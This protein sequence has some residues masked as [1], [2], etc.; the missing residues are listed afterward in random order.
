MARDYKDSGVNWID[1]IPADWEVIRLKN[2]FSFGKG[3][4]ITKE[5]L[6]ETGI[7]V[8]SYGQIHGKYNSGVRIH[9]ELIR[10]VP[11]F[12]LSSN[13]ESLVHE[14]DLILADTSEDLEGCGNCAYIDHD[15]EIFAG[16]HTIILKSASPK[17]NKYIA[18]L[19]QTDPWRS[20]IRSKV[21][22]V[23][24]LS[25]S[26]RIISDATLLLP[27]EDEQYRIADFLDKK[28][29]EIDSVI[30][31][32][33]RTIEEYKALR[34]ATITKAITKGVRNKR[35]MKD[36]G[37]VWFG[38]IPADWN[39]M[40]LKYMFHIKKDIAGQEGYTV[41]SITQKGIIPK[42][43]ANNEGQLAADYSKYQLVK[44]GDFAMNHMD[45]LTGWVDISK[46]DGVTSPDYR[47]F[48]LDDEANNKEYYL[49]MMQMCY[50]NRIFYGLGQGV[51]GMGRWR[52]QAD[53]FLNFYIAVPPVEEQN[54]IVDTL[55]K[56][57][58][59]MD[60]LIAAKEQLLTEMEA[61]KK[62]VIYAYVTG[63]KE[64]PAGQ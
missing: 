27:P 37:S 52:L 64:V 21:F 45:L 39:M 34:K 26:R 22:G 14:G 40:R 20:Q 25:V 16:Y 43:I 55:K 5:N 15:G 54:E 36:S 30:T 12:Y 53:K 46:Y 62:S 32:T 8:I 60:A 50:F 63:K 38:D 49:Y 58:T 57:L 10:Y 28:C 47:V 3:L 11:E 51:S 19:M 48:V 31:E 6:T 7:P 44:P 56:Q 17:N 35:E 1:I 13:A 41:L 23:K 9:E 2:I 33:K 42:N 61:Y 24:V 59:E 18:Y 29:A 4:P